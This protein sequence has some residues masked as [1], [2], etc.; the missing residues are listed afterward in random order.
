MT[1][2]L[3]Q[4][5]KL[6]GVE[7][8]LTQTME[9]CGE[10]VQACNKLLRAGGHGK[11]PSCS[12]DEALDMLKKELVDVNIMIDE[13]KYLLCLN[14]AELHDIAVKSVKGTNDMI[15]GNK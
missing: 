1:E 8:V 12:Y 14:S 10:L 2:M 5:A 4:N 13:L 3:K 6:L 15:F 9:E 11:K 7:N